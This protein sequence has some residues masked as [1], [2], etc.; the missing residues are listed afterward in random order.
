MIWFSLILFAV[1]FI[2]TALLA[3][4]PEV[5][6]ARPEDLD[7]NNF[8]QATED[9][10]VPLVLGCVRLSGPNTLWY[11]DFRSVPITEKIKTSIFKSTQVTV[12]YKYYL[13]LDL[14]IC[15]GPNVFLKKIYLD[16]EEV[17]SGDEFQY[18]DFEELL[19]ANDTPAYDQVFPRDWFE[20]NLLEALELTAEEYDTLAAQGDISVLYSTSFNTF[21]S[22]IFG[23]PGPVEGEWELIMN[24]QEISGTPPTGS[25]VE[26]VQGFDAM[27]LVSHAVSNP[28][29]MNIFA[30]A[31]VG[32]RY[33]NF[34]QM[35]RPVFLIF[36]TIDSWTSQISFAK[37]GKIASTVNFDIHAPE[38]YGG[39]KSGGGHIGNVTLYPGEFDQDVDPDIEASVGVGGVPAYNGVCHIAM[40]DQYIGET[41]A[42]R[43]IEFIVARYPNELSLSFQGRIAEDADDINPAG[44]LY[45]MAV[46]DWTGVDI[47]PASI[48]ADSFTTA[49]ETLIT[50]NHGC[51]IKVTTPKNAKSIFTEVLRQIDGVI[52]TNTD[53]EISL[54]LIRDDY[55]AGSLTVYDEDDII[56]VTSFDKTSWQDV[57][58]QVKVSF[59][60]RDKEGTRVAVAQNMATANMI[61]GL[62]TSNISF[63]FCYDETLANELAA[64]ELSVLSV[65]LIR[66][67]TIMNR[68]AYQLA[69][70]DPIKISLAEYGLV[71][72]ICR[73]QNVDLGEIDDNKIKIE[74]V[75]DIF[76]VADTNFAPPADTGWSQTRPEPED[77]VTFEVIEM[78]FFYGSVLDQPVED[79]FGALIPLPVSPKTESNMFDF[80][81]GTDTG[82]LDIYEPQQILYPLTG[83][84]SADYTPAEGFE[85]GLDVTGFT[86]YSVTGLGGTVPV[87]ATADEIIAGTAGILYINGEWMGYQGV[88]DHMDGSYTLDNVV[89]ALLGTL[90][91]GH[92]ENDRIYFFNKQLLSDSTLGGDLLEDGTAYYKILDRVGGTVQ[93][94]AGVLVES[95]FI[96]ND[97]ADRPMRPRNLQ[98]DSVRTWPLII[99]AGTRVLTWV[100][101][102]RNSGQVSWEQFATETPDQTEQYDLQVWVDG[103]QDG[104]R[105]VFG[106]TSP[107]NLDWS[108]PPAG[109]E[110]EIRLYATRTGG[111]TKSSYLYGLLV[112]ELDNARLL[113]SGD[114][115]SGTDRVLI[116]GDEQDTGT[117]T[118]VLTGDEA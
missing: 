39:R 115:Q 20:V 100:N 88:T 32:A 56:E 15:L 102:N 3:P 113:L 29:N 17:I 37:D 118:I 22:P 110:A 65:P 94:E 101:S 52:S 116:S 87:A 93:D 8:P 30:T 76:A 104:A 71:E 44:A 4:K 13:S 19:V 59:A 38:L 45:H 77:I 86:I 69:V 106:I 105:N 80:L 84:M 41:A 111:D 28:V 62:K 89:R 91:V 9:A 74:L 95:E 58:S 108:S 92:F 54:K 98:I 51:S 55:D 114:E 75:Q 70:G 57:K 42:L 68:N 49:A 36:T 18:E 24:W 40:P 25:E 64:R 67:T 99:S 1:S 48:N 53:G 43:T 7:P 21:A 14:G 82:V 83:L 63:P 81:T 10:P 66:M 117:D 50:E 97:I 79:G 103:I 5:E 60:T 11:G 26:P 46:N 72:L 6:N 27:H 85:T 47:D 34:H 109:A 31:P 112:L 107:Y 90:P 12:G 78:P 2:A 96:L 61:G 23:G 33:V 35:I 16:D 73:V